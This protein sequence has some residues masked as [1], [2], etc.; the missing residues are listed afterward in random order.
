MSEFLPLPMPT[1]HLLRAAG[2]TPDRHAG[3]LLDKLGQFGGSASDPARKQEDQKAILEQVAGLDGRGEAL[4]RSAATRQT[5]LEGTRA[6]RWAASTL[7]PLTLHLSRATAHENAGICLH[8]VY[9]FVYLPGSGLKGAA[10][11][12]AE[13]AWLPQQPDAAEAWKTIQRVFGASPGSDNFRSWV[14]ELTAIDPKASQAGVVV[15]HDGWP[16]RQEPRLVVDILNSHHAEYYQAGEQLVPAPG[17]WETPKLVYFLAVRAGTEF[18]F[19]LSKRRGADDSDVALAGEWLAQAL[20]HF[21]AGAKTASGYGTFSLPAEVPPADLP[22]T[23]YATLDTTV[24]LASPAFLA[25]AQQDQSDCDLR[26]ATLRGQLR[27]WWRTMHSGFVEPAVLRRMESLIWG[28]TAQQGA[29]RVE[30]E[31]AA[32]P[33][34]VPNRFTPP[35]TWKGLLYYSYGMAEKERGERSQMPPGARWKIRIT[36]KHTSES[37]QRGRVSLAPDVSLAQAKAALDLLCTFGGVG[38]KSRKG[39]GSLQ[40]ERVAD[41]GE[42]NR[43]G[44]E[45][46]H[47]FGEGDAFDASRAKSPALANCI[48]PLH[49]TTAQTDAEQL[50]DWIGR[51]MKEFV[52]P[53]VERNRRRIRQEAM[54]RPRKGL[55]DQNENARH[56]SPFLFHLTRGPDR[57]LGLRW[58]AFPTPRLPDLEHSTGVLTALREHLESKR[59]EIKEAQPDRRSSERRDR[60]RRGEQVHGISPRGASP[61]QEAPSRVPASVLQIGATV[62]GRLGPPAEPGKT[63]KVTAILGTAPPRKG[64][65]DKSCELPP[66]LGEGSDHEL[67]VWNVPASPRDELRLW[68]KT[69]DH[70]Q[71]PGWTPPKPPPARDDRGGGRRGGPPGRGSPGGGRR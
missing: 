18:D 52:S 11:A 21:G 42:C 56:A 33:M 36:A 61:R 40:A 39:F 13:L 34:P 20:H 3:L 64:Y 65:I 1:E 70:P 12:Y 16:S 55:A 45:L 2:R 26:P 66:D 9:G 48:G 54:G 37:S 41:I 59:A 38:S 17:D 23:R 35:S 14:K 31:R 4:A 71:P 58:I 10:R 67:F 22:A 69:A 28:D 30:V 8:P 5:L 50:I 47:F 43:A 57:A 24:E 60:G 25:G 49:F 7:G 51:A 53:P 29:V 27:W 44:S 32:D 6:R 19:A 62:R 46:R 63:R 15:F 68:F